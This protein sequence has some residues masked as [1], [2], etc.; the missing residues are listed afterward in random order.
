M[1][2]AAAPRRGRCAPG[3]R[4][5]PSRTRE[6]GARSGGEAGGERERRAPAGTAPRPRPRPPRPPTTAAPPCHPPLHAAP[7]W[8]APTRRPTRLR[9]ARAPRA[10]AAAATCTAP[11]T[12]L[13]PRPCSPR[14]RAG[15]SC[16]RRCRRCSRRTTTSCSSS[17]RT[18][19]PGSGA[20]IASSRS[21]GAQ[22]VR[23]APRRGHQRARPRPL[24][25]L[26]AAM[27]QCCAAGAP[28]GSKARRTAATAGSR[29]AAPSGGTRAA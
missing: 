20:P 8:N 25:R 28:R 4:P 1:V 3:M 15:C 14:R 12:A 23:R 29:W 19:R 24:R 9:G 18:S 7:Q 17:T 10:A 5:E 27:G 2:R 13:S 16:S 6:G 22:A 11:A 26:A 21:L